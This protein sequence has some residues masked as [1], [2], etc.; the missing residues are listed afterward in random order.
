M[1][2]TFIYIFHVPY[3]QVMSVIHSSYMYTTVVVP[4]TQVSHCPSHLL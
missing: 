4:V 3:E 1:L 2:M